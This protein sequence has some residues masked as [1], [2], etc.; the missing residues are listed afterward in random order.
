MTRSKSLSRS[1]NSSRTG[2]AISD[3]SLMGVPSCFS[4]GLRMVKCTRSTE[5]SDFSSARMGLAGDQQHLQ[6]VA[7]AVDQ[8]DGRV[9]GEAQLFRPWLDGELEDVLPA[10]VD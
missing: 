7:H 3:S 2:K 4:G 6:P 9:V 5:G 8:R 1:S 10:M